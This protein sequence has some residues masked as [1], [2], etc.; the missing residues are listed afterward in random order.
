[1]QILDPKHPFFK[2]A[3]RR[4]LTVLLPAA[5]GLVELSN[6]AVGWAIAFFAAAGYAAYELLIMYDRR[7]AEN[8]LPSEAEERDQD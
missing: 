7:I 4:W 2:P 1:M 8:S 3:W 6:N 5:W